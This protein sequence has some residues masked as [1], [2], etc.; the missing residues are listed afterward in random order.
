M[1]F[2]IGDIKTEIL[3]HQSVKMANM[4]ILS[5]ICYTSNFIEF[6]IIFILPRQDLGISK[7][8]LKCETYGR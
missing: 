1:L 4:K 6:I 7:A 3:L 8:R 2:W 5:R